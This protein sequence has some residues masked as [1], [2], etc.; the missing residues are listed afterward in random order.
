ML[1]LVFIV[2]LSE[3][4]VGSEL[5]LLMVSSQSMLSDNQFALGTF[6]MKWK[7]KGELM[8]DCHS[9][10]VTVNLPSVIFKTLP[11]SVSIG[12]TRNNNWLLLLNQLVF[13]YTF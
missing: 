1:S 9:A 3:R 8:D 11:Y 5:H 6:K 4:D 7:R 12:K 2:V 13:I 10:I